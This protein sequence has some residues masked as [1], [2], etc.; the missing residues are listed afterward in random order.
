MN[1]TIG[2]AADEDR[3][4]IRRIHTAAFGQ[5]AEAELVDALIDR[6]FATASLVAK[7]KGRA[8][9]IALRRPCVHGIATESRRVKRP[10]RRRP[11]RSAVCSVALN[12]RKTPFFSRF[13]VEM[14]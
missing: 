9:R 3:A 8:V 6:G 10:L 14:Q 12:P 2:K 4:D 11:L 5:T 1:V 7:I 13:R